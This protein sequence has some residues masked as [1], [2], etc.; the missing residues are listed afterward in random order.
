MPAARL[1]P[2]GIDAVIDGATLRAKL[3]EA[4][5]GEGEGARETAKKLL[6][7]ALTAGRTLARQRLEAGEN[8]VAVARLLSAVAD[9]VVSALYDFTTTHVFRARNP[10]QGERFAIVAVG[11]YGRG[12]LAPFSDLDLLFLRAYKTTPFSESV[13]EYMLYMLWDLGLKVGHASR[14][15]DEN[16]KLARAD[17]TIETAILEARHIAGDASLSGELIVRFRREVA[18]HDHPAFIAAKLKERDERHVRSGA[19]RYMVEP[20][21][22]EGKGGLRDLHTLFWLARHRYGFVRPRDYLDAGVFTAEEGLTFR[23]ALEFFWTVRCHMHFVAGRAEERLTFDLQPTIARRLGYRSRPNQSAT[24]RFMRR[25]FL[26]AKQVGV[27]TRILCA[28]LEADHA[29]RAP[30]G[31]Q[32]FLP[33]ARKTASPIEAGF[34]VEGGRLSIASPR[35]FDDPANLIRLFEIADRRDLDIHPLALGEASNRARGL[36]PA[37]RKD[38]AARASFLAVAASHRHPGAALKMMNEADVLG[39]FVPEFGRIVAQMQFNMYHHYTV[40]EHTLQAIEAMSEIEKGAHKN[41][42]PLSTELFPK[43]VNRRALY[44]AMLLHDT[45]KGEGDQQIEGE[46]SARVACERLGLP[47]EEVDL[48]GWLVRHHLVMSDVAQKRDIGDPR[49]VAQ[50]AEIVGTVERLRLLLVLTVSDIRAVGPNVWNDWKGQLLRDLYRLTEAVLHGRSDEEGV[51][52]HLAEIAGLAKNELRAALH[53]D[54]H[55]LDEWFGALD[56]GYWL[57]H[58]AEARLW[59]ARE[60]LKART[61][62][63]IPHVAVRTRTQQGV[64]EVLIYAGD[65]PGLFASLAAAISASGANIADA[66]VHTTKDGAA[67]DVFSIQTADHRPFGFDNPQAL[68]QLVARLLRATL[69]DY[70]APPMQAASRRM[71]AFAIEPWVRIDND[72]TTQATVVEASGRDRLGLLADLASVCAKERVSIVSAHIDT[73]GER[74]S[75][76]FYVQEQGGGQI[77]EPR[78]IAAL[79]SKLEA[80]LR[81]AEPAA[82]TGPDKPSLAV[83]RASTAR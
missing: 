65:R 30:R 9:E 64:A 71:A 80:V 45:G 69:E 15:I 4:A 54:E 46:K 19:S 47:K 49:T 3:T 75:D 18:Q 67:F 27:L 10:T 33:P 12:E 5:L 70:P 59:H 32:R 28:R 16:L 68:D 72:I 24:E 36:P 42:H 83:A 77:A 40:D 22:K 73:Y 21:I 81:A 62:R 17:H 51:R 1:K 55:A 31:L 26:V 56:D 41:Q 39:R 35:T 6:Q 38:E 79:K 53:G 74:A 48:I 60:V 29:K 7:E 44:L 8:G 58:D 14:N 63:A 37:W 66:R 76:V 2:V 34:C 82:P 52:A 13:T 20:N 11:G 61:E 43:I 50:F 25:Y 78:R 23:R 57:N